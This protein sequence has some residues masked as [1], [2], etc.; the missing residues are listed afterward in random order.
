LI[1]SCDPAD[2]EGSLYRQFDAMAE[3][4]RQVTKRQKKI[5]AIHTLNSHLQPISI[6]MS[7]CI[8]VAIGDAS[9]GN[10]KSLPN[11]D[12]TVHDSNDD[13]EDIV[14][15]LNDNQRYIFDQNCVTV[16]SPDHVQGKC[17]R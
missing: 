17:F 1:T 10:D 16:R 13:V 8:D 2:V 14:Q 11:N 3:D 5:K 12:N 9:D 4:Q 7:D 15:S 6:Q